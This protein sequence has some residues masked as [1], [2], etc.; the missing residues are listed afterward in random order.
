M[1]APILSVSDDLTEFEARVLDV[2]A[3]SVRPGHSPSREELS[4]GA[5]L[6]ARGYRISALLGSL[7]EKGYLR[8]SPGQSRS[9]TLLRLA[10]GRPLR[11]ETIRV[12]VVGIIGASHPRETAV[13]TDGLFGSDEAIELTRGLVGQGEGIFALRVSGDSMVEAMIG[14]GDLV[15]LNAA[16]EIHN[17]DMVAAAVAGD[18]GGSATTLK[19]YFRDDGCVRLVAANP[20]LP[21]LPAYRPDQVTVYGKVILIIRQVGEH[22]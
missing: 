4:R 6:G 20:A 3:R 1:P 2:L 16:A 9:I 7:Q 21:P 12:P 13:Q 11:S 19:Y 5:G 10:D 18:D 14:N 15:V 17:G 22:P 8:L